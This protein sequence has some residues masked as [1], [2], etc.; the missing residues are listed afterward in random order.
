MLLLQQQFLA[1]LIGQQPS[2]KTKKIHLNKGQTK[3]EQNLSKNYRIWHV[4]ST[5][6]I[7]A[8]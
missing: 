8:C 6:N 2:I 1:F 3:S 4:H 5:V 7:A